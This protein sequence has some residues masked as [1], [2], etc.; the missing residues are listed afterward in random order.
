MP[1]PL[2][3]IPYY[4]YYVAGFAVATPF[5]SRLISD[6]NLVGT[7]DQTAPDRDAPAATPKY[8]RANDTV[9]QAALADVVTQEVK[10]HG[11]RVDTSRVQHVAI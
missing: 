3:L 1:H 10:G 9:S 2:R 5:L 11:D 7:P 4:L 6:T 8:L